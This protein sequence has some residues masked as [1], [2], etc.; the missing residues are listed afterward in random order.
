MAVQEHFEGFDAEPEERS[1]SAQKREAQEIRKLA[2]KIADLGDLSFKQLNFPDDLIKESLMVARSLKIN[3]DERRRQLQYVAKLLRNED[4][5][6]LRSQINSL[7]ATP[8][9][10]LNA[11]K[12]ENLRENMILGGIK[13]I[14]EFCSLIQDTDRNK[15]RNLVKKAQ[16]ELKEERVDRPAAR[17][18]FKLL[19]A[20]VKR[21]GVELPS[22]LCAKKEDN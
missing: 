13:V 8:K 22:S 21:S 19:K 5:D 4:L 15:L 2:E 7:G 12:L 3:S 9:A 10:D 1:R 14:N 17:T 11:L 18:L 6:D 16:E 20:E